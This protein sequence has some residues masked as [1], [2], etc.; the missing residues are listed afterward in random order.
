MCFLVK[1]RTM[2]QPDLSQFIHEKLHKMFLALMVGTPRGHYNNYK[3]Q[4]L[5]HCISPTDHGLPLIKV[6]G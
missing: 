5:W 4:A 6:A 1:L 2:V 3:P